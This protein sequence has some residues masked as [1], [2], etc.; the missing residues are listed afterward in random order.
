MNDGR[1]KN[2]VTDIVLV[3]VFSA[4][5][6]AASWLQIN[7]PT[8]LGNTRIHLGNVL[9]LLSGFLLGALRGGT[10][11]GLGSMLFDFT[12]P[13]FI[14]SAPFTLV[15]KFI[16]GFLCG[17]LGARVRSPGVR[18]TVC[19][20]AAAVTGQLAYIALYLAKGYWWDAILIK[21]ASAEIAWADVIVTKAPVSLFNGV[22]AVVI[23]VPLALALQ[24]TLK[25]TPLYGKFLMGRKDGT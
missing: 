6:F 17:L 22:L 11:A 1:K 5:V 25:G 20:V 23:S 15:F 2:G 8:P 9:C 19:K 14:T 18:D 24:K 21:G 16:M 13:I 7:I 4:L 10:A 3:G 12:S